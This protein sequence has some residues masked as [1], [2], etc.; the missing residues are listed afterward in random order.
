MAIKVLSGILVT[1]DHQEG[2]VRIDLDTNRVA[3]GPA[4][5]DV[6]KGRMI[7]AGRYSELPCKMVALRE[8]KVHSVHPGGPHRD[9]VENEYLKINDTWID[10][11]YMEITWEG[12]SGSRIEEI[13][14]MVIGETP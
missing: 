4:G 7:G 13:S 6:E 14:Y 2:R 8:I 12:T 9:I 11:H 5:M 1:R 10:E 3:D